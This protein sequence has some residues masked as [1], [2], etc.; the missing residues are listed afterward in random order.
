MGKEEMKDIITAHIKRDVLLSTL[1]NGRRYDGRDLEEIRKIQIQ[2][3]AINTAEGSALVKL[4]ETQ[5][6]VATKFDIVKPFADRPKEGVMVTNGELLPIAS[7]VFEPGP[8]DEYSIEM[9]R[10][11]DRAIRSAECFDLKSFYVEQD[12]VLGLYLD[13]YVLNHSGNYTDAA[14]LAATAALM[15]TKMPKI[16]NGAIIRGEY[17][18]L[19]RLTSLPI[20]TTMTKIGDYWIVDPSRDEEL[21][22]ETFITIGTTEEHVCTIQKGKGWLYKEEL[23]NNIDI[24]FKR[25]NDIRSILSSQ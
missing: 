21:V 22:G 13:I 8:P 2:P 7:P 14:T 6:L 18:G 9:A 11:V 12:K 19:L 1:N 20:T 10:V 3:N 25:G 16:E 4:G 17:E 5:V 24:A 23:M 15:N